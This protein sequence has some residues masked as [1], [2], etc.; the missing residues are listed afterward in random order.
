MPENPPRVHDRGFG[1]AL[2]LLSA[3]STVTG[4][5]VAILLDWWGG[6]AV[7][8]AA[9]LML[10]L[11]LRWEMRRRTQYR[12]ALLAAQAQTDLIVPKTGPL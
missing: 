2:I 6:L 5:V 3:L 10:S 12:R 8:L 9:V 1:L 11:F 4:L 7:F